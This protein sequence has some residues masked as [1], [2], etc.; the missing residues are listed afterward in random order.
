M[1]SLSLSSLTRAADNIIN[2]DQSGDDFNLK[3]EQVGHNNKILLYNATS[4]ITGDDVAIHLHQHNVKNS[5]DANTIK[6]W[7]IYG[8][9]NSIRW[10]QG[11]GLSNS[12]DTTF[13]S[14]NS[15]G[16]GQY[17]LIDIH[18]NRNSIAGYQMNAGSGAHTADIYIWGDDNSAWLR[19]KNNESKNLDLLIKNDDNVVS[20]L[21]K[22]HA[23]HSATI[24]LDGTYGTNLNLTQQ[25]NTAQSY[26]LIQ[27]C[28]TSGGCSI[29]ITQQN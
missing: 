3:I 4:K 8:D 23:A 15:E 18:G 26:T 10:G 27:N 24:T 9:N 28:Q 25:S 29:S 14:D 2:M 5:S 16:P 13:S 12:S 17:A 22:D 6:L 21:Q 20:V 19:Q 1:V 11:A 7:H